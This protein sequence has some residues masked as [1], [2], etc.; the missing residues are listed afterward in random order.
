MVALCPAGDP[1]EVEK[2]AEGPP[3]S[4]EGLITVSVST[5][6]FSASPWEAPAG[7]SFEARPR[8]STWALTGLA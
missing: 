1:A 8:N 5:P 4:S 3:I 2:P 7:S 6:A